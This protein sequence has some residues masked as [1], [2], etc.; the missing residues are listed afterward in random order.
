MSSVRAAGIVVLGMGRA[1]TRAA[2]SVIVVRGTRQ[3]P[4][5]RAVS[6]QIVGKRRTRAAEAR[7]PTA[8]AASAFIRPDAQAR[9]PR[10]ILRRILVV[11]LLARLVLV[12]ADAV[13]WVLWEDMRS[14]RC[15]RSGVLG[16]FTAFLVAALGL[17]VLVFVAGMIGGTVLMTTTAIVFPLGPQGQADGAPPRT[18]ATAQLAAR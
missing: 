13:C 6:A 18:R 4:G 11:L 14:T 10:P 5:G 16:S 12:L 7:A 15:D 8:A 9:A 17:V 1:V 3:G 2:P